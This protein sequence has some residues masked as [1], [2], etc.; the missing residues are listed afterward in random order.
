MKELQIQP[1][2]HLTI[3]IHFVESAQ[4]HPEENM[5]TPN[6]CTVIALIDFL[7]ILTYIYSKVQNC[8]LNCMF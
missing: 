4:G 2:H 8:T 7:L 3:E 5:L 1:S 6:V